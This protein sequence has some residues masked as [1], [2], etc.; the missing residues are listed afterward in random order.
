MNKPAWPRAGGSRRS[1]PTDPAPALLVRLA[2]G[3]ERRAGETL[4]HRAEATRDEPVCGEWTHFIGAGGRIWRAECLEGTSVWCVFEDVA[5]RA[6]LELILGGPGAQRTTALE[7][8]I[9]TDVIER[10]LAAG[11][12]GWAEDDGARPAAAH[13]WRC[14]VTIASD[15]R[16]HARFSLV[17]AAAAAPPTPAAERINA[18]P[19]PLSLTASLAPVSMRLAALIEWRAGSIVPLYDAGAPPIWLLAGSAL[20]GSGRLGASRGRRAVRLD[21]PAQE[22]A[23]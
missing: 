3:I 13:A 18:G 19:I 5:I 8:G 17:A 15:K 2:E 23:R 12:H 21:G 14:N 11:D 20:I 7:R 16:V 22:R 1:P 9:I 10:L 6:L 4:R